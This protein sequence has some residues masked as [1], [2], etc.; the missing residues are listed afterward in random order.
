MGFRVNIICII[1]ECESLRLLP[2]CCF[3]LYSD[4][5]RDIGF[6]IFELF[7]YVYSDLVV[8][9]VW[10]S[11]FLL[12]FCLNGLICWP[13]PAVLIYYQ[14][15]YQNYI[16]SF[17]LSPWQFIVHIP[18]FFCLFFICYHCSFLWFSD[19][20]LNFH[21]FIYLFFHNIKHSLYSSF[22]NIAFFY[23]LLIYTLSSFFSL[24]YSVF[25]L[26][27]NLSLSS[28]FSPLTASFSKFMCLSS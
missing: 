18:I 6:H 27:F 7:I 25:L 21:L 9:W 13:S 2:C 24:A 14:Y 10:S 16:T 5:R 19:M 17:S 8:C 15:C 11:F 3:V 1:Y 23:G 22:S 12:C 20:Y 26:C 4:L 28:S